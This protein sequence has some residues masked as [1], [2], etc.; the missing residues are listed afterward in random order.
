M[1]HGN[2]F[3]L[4]ITFLFMI[5]SLSSFAEEKII[6]TPLINIDKIKPSFDEIEEKNEDL[7]SSQNLREKKKNNKNLSTPHA[8]LIG[9]DKITA[10]S[11]KIKIVT[12]SAK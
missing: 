12:I 3:K 8:V 6:T 11:S 10:K 1:K 5:S 7:T 2:K 4:V 9:L